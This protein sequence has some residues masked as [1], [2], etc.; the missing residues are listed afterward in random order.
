[1]PT[2]Q[3]GEVYEDAFKVIFAHERGFV[4]DTGGP[5]NDGI[6]LSELIAT[7]NLMFD[8]NKDK[9][10]DLADLKAL[11]LS[12]KRYYYYTYWW[13]KYGIDQVPCPQ[14]QNLMLDFFINMGPRQ[15]TICFQRALRCLHLSPEGGDDGIFGGKTR[16]SLDKV[17]QGGKVEVFIAS[18]RSECAGFYR[19]LVATQPEKFKTYSNGWLRRAYGEF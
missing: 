6:T 19:L 16:E 15:A 5:T 18:L 2:S 14:I 10:I 11:K 12:H 17:I 9:K 13:I 7:K 1:M 4:V 3:Y 8:L